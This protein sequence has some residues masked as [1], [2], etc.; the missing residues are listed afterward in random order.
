MKRDTIKQEIGSWIAG[1]A[2]YE[3]TGRLLAYC[4]GR[5]LLREGVNWKGVATKHH[6]DIRHITDWECDLRP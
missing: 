3:E 1:I 6:L 5:L 4:V 2:N